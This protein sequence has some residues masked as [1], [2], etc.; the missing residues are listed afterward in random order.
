MVY[1]G[2]HLDI[3]FIIDRS[4]SMK[5]DINSV[6][7]NIESFTTQLINEGITYR[8]GLVTYEES[9]IDYS[10][11]ESVDTFKDNLSNIDVG[12]GDENGLDAI[13]KAIDK[14]NFYY[15]SIKYFV[16]IGDA[17]IAGDFSLDYV[18]NQLKDNDIIL[19]AVGV[20]KNKYQF[21]KLTEAT[22]GQFLNLS[23]NFSRNLTDIFDQIQNIPE[24]LTVFP[25]S[26]KYYGRNDTPF[27]PTITISDEDSDKLTC[28]YYLD[29]ESTPRDTVEVTNTMTEQQVQFSALDIHALNDGPHSIT[30]NVSD[31]VDT[32]HET[33][34]FSIDTNEPTIQNF[35]LSVSDSQIILSGQAVD[36]ASGMHN[37]PYQ[38]QLDNNVTTWTSN[39][40][41]TFS[42][43]SPDHSYQVFFRARD[44]MGN[45]ALRQQSVYT[46]A[47]T[48]DV[49]LSNVQTSAFDIDV[50]DNNPASTYYQI[51]CHS[52]YVNASGQLTTQPQW[53]RLNNKTIRVKGIKPNTS[54]TIKAKARNQLNSETAFS[55]SKSVTTLIHPPANIQL[56]P[57]QTFIDLS[58]TS[59]QGAQSY[60]IDAGQSILSVN[61]TLSQYRIQGLQPDTKYTYR[62]RSI[63]TGGKGPWS[64]YYSE[65]T[66]PIP[67]K[68]PTAF[69]ASESQTSVTLT[70]SEVPRAEFYEIEADTDIRKIYGT[71]YKHTS[72]IPDSHHKY[73]VRAVNRGGQSPWTNELSIATLPYPPDIPNGITLTPAN[74]SITV[75]WQTSARAE[76]YE[77]E[78][79]GVIVNNNASTTYCHEGLN[80]LTLHQYRIRAV[81]RGGK[82]TW[83][84]IQ[85][86]VTHP[87]A[88]IEP[89]QLYGTSSPDE[90]T[91]MWNHVPHADEYVIE[92]DGKTQHKTTEANYV[93]KKLKPDQAHTYRVKARN[94]T[95]ESPWSKETVISTLPDMGEAMTLTNVGAIVTNN[96]IILSW[97]AVDKDA[98]YEIE[99]DGK[100]V[101]VGTHTLFNHEG[102]DAS[103]FHTYKVKVKDSDNN[104]W[105]S[106]LSLSTLPNPP[107]APTGFTSTASTD[108]II[109]NWDS[110]NGA[111]RYDLEIDGKVIDIGNIHEFIHSSLKSG[112]TYTY[113]VRA[114]NITGVTAWSE[115]IKQSTEVPNYSLHLKEGEEVE[116]ALMAS[117]VQDFS[118]TLFKVDYDA[119]TL[120]IIDLCTYTPMLDAASQGK[121]P[122]TGLTAEC[123]YGS[124]ELKLHKPM[125]PGTSWSGEVNSIRFR[126]KRN[127]TT[128]ITFSLEKDN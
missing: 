93:H 58:W 7:N 54:Y 64:D 50:T 99:V 90:I 3:V 45:T 63:N 119:N 70:W 107:D 75:N 51:M 19:T 10:L 46:D 94:I 71:S 112:N 55:P 41:H 38:Y 37:Q 95:G 18:K 29:N 57:S 17:E 108:Y 98:E 72:L 114:K 60:E 1:A 85:Y 35:S 100:M 82:S 115:A 125:V 49:T 120:E 31:G 42:S 77:I 78:V 8:L 79:D 43:L 11:T 122:D 33:I 23:S 104:Y 59:R 110:S 25:E 56:K 118:E 83:S 48:P 2:N 81:N 21:K 128:E 5:S 89:D 87:D 105:A 103:T 96:F 20:N 67:P 106:V 80:P 113:R 97:D 73:R 91:I 111:Q 40:A 102:L 30:F 109:L 28:T 68:A 101:D 69:N 92:V 4:G 22:K 15:N 47:D 61:G 62:I 44:N 26:S 14:Y 126:A 6:R 53:I 65:I 32:V 13:M 88:P 9:V 24:F 39:T 34:A 116:I 16:L 52:S 27:I 124:I 12:G 74:R 66:L 86:V 121:I 123:R 84:D 117:H 76:T 127:G 36:N